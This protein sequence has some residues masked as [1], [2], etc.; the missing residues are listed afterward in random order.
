MFLENPHVAEE[1]TEAREAMQFAQGPIV[2]NGKISTLSP[3]QSSFQQIGP[4]PL[5]VLRLKIPALT[6]F[7]TWKQPS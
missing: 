7:C 1:E 5:R 4:P 6:P 2:S 3:G